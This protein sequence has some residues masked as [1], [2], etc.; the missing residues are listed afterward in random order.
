MLFRYD[1]SS[2]TPA[3]E[4]SHERSMAMTRTIV[5][6]VW[7]YH[8]FRWYHARD[9]WQ[10][11]RSLESL[12]FIRDACRSSSSTACLSRQANI[13]KNL[14]LMLEIFTVM[15]SVR[16]ISAPNIFLFRCFLRAPIV[17]ATISAT[18]YRCCNLW[19]I[20]LLIDTARLPFEGQTHTGAKFRLYQLYRDARIP[21]IM[22]YDPCASCDDNAKCANKNSS[23][24]PL[25][26]VRISGVTRDAIANLH[27]FQA[28][29][30]VFSERGFQ[31]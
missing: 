31:W 16:V 25:V 24:L 17:A 26:R 28:P 12:S 1:K 21:F 18:R 6:C 5:K 3:L 4:H 9:A 14:T 7:W 20:L 15:M 10:Q 13:I 27:F 2:S 11:F 8:Y 23:Y 29:G 19:S 30:R 22:W